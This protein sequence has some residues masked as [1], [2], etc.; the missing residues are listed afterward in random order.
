[1]Q[2]IDYSIEFCHIYLNETFSHEHRRSIEVLRRVI[3]RLPTG[4]TYSLNVLIDDY[5][6]TEEL[7]DI[8]DLITELRQAEVAPDYLVYEARLV[9]YTN[10][11]LGLMPE[12]RLKRSYERYM[13]NQGVTPCSFMIAIWY[14][15]RLGAMP[16]QEDATVYE[17]N[18][19]HAKPFVAERLISILP[20]RFEGV[21]RKAASIIAATEFAPLEER[22]R[23]VY[24]DSA[25]GRVHAHAF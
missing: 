7:L 1:M 18:G 19:G 10:A 16:L 22:I 2:T 3:S 11:L 25:D 24:Y 9:P 23:R 4:T 5:N 21:E 8:E 17:K 14:L 6:A 13:R 20:E 12:G 15:L